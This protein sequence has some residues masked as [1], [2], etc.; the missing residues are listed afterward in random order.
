M[1]VALKPGGSI[2]L[3]LAGTGGSTSKNGPLVLSEGVDRLRFK[4]LAKN[5]YSNGFDG[6]EVRKVLRPPTL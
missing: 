1:A 4:R 6:I 5:L 2:F 3:T